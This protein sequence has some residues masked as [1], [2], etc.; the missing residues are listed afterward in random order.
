ME[1]KGERR[2]FI[3]FNPL[4]LDFVSGAYY[5]YKWHSC[6]TKRPP[7]FS[8]LVPLLT[9]IDATT[10]YCTLLFNNDYPS[11]DGSI[12]RSIKLSNGTTEGRTIDTNR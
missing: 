2:R 12:V 4:M 10:S 6:G 3:G 11:Y 7:L 5:V 1:Q 8:G 9:G